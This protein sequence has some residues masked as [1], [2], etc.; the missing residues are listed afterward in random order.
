[1]S[2]VVAIKEDGKIYMGADTMVTYGDSKRYLTTEH[3][4]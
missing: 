4:Q 2:V 1:M 3:T